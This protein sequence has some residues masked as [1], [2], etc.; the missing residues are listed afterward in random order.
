MKRAGKLFICLFALLFTVPLLMGQTAKKNTGE[1]YQNITKQFANPPAEYS[2][3]P[4]WVWNEKITKQRIDENLRDYKERGLY[5]L[6]LHPRPGLITPYLNNEWFSLVKYAVDKAKSLGMKIWLY[7]ENSYPSGFAGGNVPAQMPETRGNMLRLIKTGDLSKVN[8][9]IAF[10]MKK[11]GDKY[12]EISKSD[13]KP[14]EEYYVFVY[15]PAPE[16][17]WYGGYY[18]VDLMQRKTTDEFIKLT[19]GGYKKTIGGEFGK[20]VMGMF[21]DEPNIRV[22]Y[23]D[24]LIAYTPELFSYF[25]KKWGYD[26]KENLPLLF[27]ET[28]NWRKVRHNYN[29]VLLDLFSSNWAVPYSQYGEKNNLPMTGHYWEHDWP[30]PRNCPDN[31]AMASYSQ[32]P[33]IDL[34]MNQWNDRAYAQFGNSRFVKELGSVANQMGRKRTLSETYG[35]S[36]W[37]LTFSDMK[38]IG[39]WEYALGVNLMNQHLSYYSIT[40]SRKRDHPLSFSYHEP[41]WPDYKVLADYFSRLSYALTRGRQENKI[42]VLEPT[43]TGW[44]YYNLNSAMNNPDPKQGAEKVFPKLA[45]SFHAFVNNLEKWQIEYDLGC[46]D[47]MKRFGSVDN[48]MLKVGQASYNLFVIP[49]VTDN[50]DSE[51]VQLLEKFLKNGGRVLSTKE[52][53]GY[54]NGVESGVI[55]K[56]ASEYKNNWKQVENITAAEINSM[57]T[58]SIYFTFENGNNLVFHHRRTVADGEIIFIANTADSLNA[59][60]SFSVKAG[61]VELLN[62]FTGKTEKY[63]FKTSDGWVEVNFDMPRSGSMLFYVKPAAAKSVKKE[64]YK[65]SEVPFNAGMSIERNAPN[66]LTI[67]YCDLKI[68]DKTWKDIYFY[69]A[70]VETFKAVGM[71][72]SPWDNS[73]QYQS[74][75]IN[76]NKFPEGSGFTADYYFTL[77]SGVDTKSL[78]LVSEKPSV[79]Q[80]LINDKPIKAEKGK[81]WLD[82]DFGVYNISGYVKTGVNKV[83]VKVTPMSIYAELESVYILGNFSLVPQEKG[84]KITPASKIELGPWNKQ[85]M[86]LYGNKVS[87]TRSINADKGSENYIVRLGRWEGSTAEVYVNGKK[88]GIIGFAPFELDITKYLRKGENKITVSVIGTLR[89]TLGPHHSYSNGSCWPS[90]FQS[91]QKGYTLAGDSYAGNPYGL[92]D[93]FKVIKR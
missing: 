71:P 22:A 78:R 47:I 57:S 76:K 38:R 66:V 10:I 24:N 41:Y 16:G 89:N 74:D 2:T 58:P 68:G 49:P 12:S 26:L 52:L 46:E 8:A 69:P 33:G 45:E 90:M 32:V 9:E 50:L 7:D 1:N 31:M 82:K 23:G 84:F 17:S 36:G 79:F 60:G 53:P 87:Y 28:G 18:Y 48:N 15:A 65:E 34:L 40:G 37:D 67:D 27:D 21:T 59:K 51:T 25:K 35:A 64:I 55:A 4:F 56:L 83:T 5:Q 20:T 42:L 86:P 29:S 61:N 93:E 75:I 30:A 73:V 81:W 43:T 91:M 19:H 54:V 92:M 85:G 44:I 6:I 70:Q 80:V 13:M 11:E 3:A 63:P 62:C 39:D 77:D 72:R 88:A 14:G